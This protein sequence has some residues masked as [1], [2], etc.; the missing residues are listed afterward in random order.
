MGFITILQ[1]PVPEIVRKAR[2]ALEQSGIPCKVR[3]ARRNKGNLL[4]KILIG[5][6]APEDNGGL[7]YELRVPKTQEI[8]AHNILKGIQFEE[9]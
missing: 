1:T 7:Q 5:G 4:A 6:F 9:D 3:Y 2:A 8:A